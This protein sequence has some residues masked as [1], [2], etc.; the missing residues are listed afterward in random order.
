MKALTGDQ[1]FLLICLTPIPGKQYEQYPSYHQRLTD[2]RR[3]YQSSLFLTFSRKLTLLGRRASAA[4]QISQRDAH[5][6]PVSPFSVLVW[7]RMVGV[8]RNSSTRRRSPQCVERWSRG[9]DF[10]LQLMGPPELVPLLLPVG[11]GLASCVL[12]VFWEGGNFVADLVSSG[13]FLA[14]CAGTEGMR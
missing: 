6:H 11:F 3:G 7:R 5:L 2:P 10:P 13:P 12:L 9:Q 1:S 4:V 14:H 8:S